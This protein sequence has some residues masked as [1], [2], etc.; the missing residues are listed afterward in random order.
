MKCIDNIIK[1]AN[2]SYRRGNNGIGHP[3][4]CTPAQINAL[5]ERC[6]AAFDLQPCHQYIEMLRM[7]DGI[8]YDGRLIYAHTTQPLFGPGAVTSRAVGSPDIDG[9]GELNRFWRNRC[10]VPAD[11]F[12]YGGSEI[13]LYVGFGEDRFCFVPNEALPREDLIVHVD[14]EFG[15]FNEM[16]H[17]IFQQL[18]ERARD[19]GDIE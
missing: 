13:Y 7:L 1:A 15:S 6:T 4:G 12:I 18:V 11:V 3:V 8:M 9:F 10:L 17:A 2:S 19:R 5:L 16:L 14:R